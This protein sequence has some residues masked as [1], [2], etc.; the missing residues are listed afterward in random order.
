MPDIN[1]LPEGMRRE[2]KSKNEIRHE[3]ISYTNPE[4]NKVEIAEG[5]FTKT[6][7]PGFWEEFSS[8]RAEAEEMK[9]EEKIEET[10]EKKSFTPAEVKVSPDNLSSSSSKLTKKHWWQNLFRKEKPKVSLPGPELILPKAPIELSHAKPLS[11]VPPAPATYSPLA[12]TAQVAKPQGSGDSIKMH[13]P[14]GKPGPDKLEVDLAADKSL[15]FSPADLVRKTKIGLVILVLFLIIVGS[16]YLIMIKMQVPTAGDEG[17]VAETASLEQKIAEYEKQKDKVVA[18]DGSLK[19][20][21]KILAGHYNWSK[22]FTLLETNTLPDVYYLNLTFDET[23]GVN[24]SLV[25]RDYD[26]LA[27]QLAIWQKTSVV[28]DINFKGAALVKETITPE[29]PADSSGK[30]ATKTVEEVNVVTTNLG[31]YLKPDFFTQ[32]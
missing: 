9:K 1:L 30:V 3:E 6:K 22:L 27:K 31:L 16:L 29:V 26:T 13:L 11:V 21:N 25:A 18:L 23:G 5:K 19:E 8:R 2:E 10:R 17:L 15:Q 12:S 14:S 32:N 24:L 20:L 4:K 7:R 28:T